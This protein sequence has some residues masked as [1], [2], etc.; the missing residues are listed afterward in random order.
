MRFTTRNGALAF[1][2]ALT[3]QA[4]T[5]ANAAHAQLTDD[6]LQEIRATAERFVG[7][8]LV[9]APDSVMSTLA[10]DAVLMPHHGVEPVVGT[11]E[12]RA[13]WWPPHS[14][15]RVLVF[16][17]TYEEIDGDGDLAY[18]RGR[19]ELALEFET[20]GGAQRASYEGNYLMLL[21]RKDGGEWK[22]THRIWNDPLPQPE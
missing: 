16:D 6:D 15:T 5:A 10:E 20:Q 9:D 2:L 4:G 21:R 11:A 14:A 1:A 12:I 17:Q 22:I 13:F 18:A 8:W 19:F 7:S 3:I